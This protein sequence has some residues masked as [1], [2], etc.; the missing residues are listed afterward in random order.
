MKPTT[1]YGN[2]SVTTSRRLRVE[3]GDPAIVHIRDEDEASLTDGQTVWITGSR[4]VLNHSTVRS[5]N[6]E[7][8]NSSVRNDN[9]TGLRQLNCM[10]RARYFKECVSLD[11][12][13]GRRELVNPVCCE[14]SD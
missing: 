4:Y 5:Y 3:D 8:A 1:I 10:L 13:A 2:F 6:A 12:Y 9:V 7:F 14:T 11:E